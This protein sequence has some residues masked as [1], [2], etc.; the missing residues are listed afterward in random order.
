VTTSTACTHHTAGAIVRIPTYAA[1]VLGGVIW[2]NKPTTPHAIVK[3]KAASLRLDRYHAKR[4]LY[5]LDRSRTFLV[6]TNDTFVIIIEFR[7]DAVD[8]QLGLTILRNT[9]RSLHFKRR[10]VKGA[11]K[12][13]G[14]KV[15]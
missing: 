14:Q 15:Q 8:A 10:L 7:L 4:A 1:L 5:I 3:L 13:T 11:L 12:F 2:T 9:F 6:S